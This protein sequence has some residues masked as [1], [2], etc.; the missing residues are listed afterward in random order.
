[1]RQ[2]AHAPN[3]TPAKWYTRQMV[4]AP[5]GTHPI[6]SLQIGILEM[7]IGILVMYDCG[8]WGR[9]LDN[10]IEYFSKG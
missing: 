9:I 2:M 1:M 10:A 5:N 7:H 6:L 4:Q 8:V 3:G